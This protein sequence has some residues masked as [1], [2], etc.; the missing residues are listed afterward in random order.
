MSKQST[1]RRLFNYAWQFKRGIILGIIF[2]M[3]ATALE[4]A[5]PFIAKTIIDDHI[6]GIESVWYESEVESEASTVSFNGKTYVRED[7]MTT[8][9][10]DQAITI[11][12]ID[13]D[14]YAVEGKAPLEGSRTFS[15]GKMTIEATERVQ[16]PAEK[17]K[18]SELYHFFKVEQKPIFY[19]LLLYVILLLIAAVFEYFQTYKLQEASNQIIRQMRNDVF[20][21]TQKI[22]LSYYVDQPAGKIVARITNDTEAIRE[23]YERVLSIVITR[24]IYM[25]GILVAIYLLQ[26]KIAL[27]ALLI[28]PLI[29]VWAWIYKYFG[30]RFNLAIRKANSEINGTINESIQGMSIIQAFQAEKRRK[31]QFEELN[32]EIYTEQKK[33]ITLNALTSFNLVT[34]IRNLTFVC[35]IV[36]FGNLSFEP[37]TAISIGMLYA[38][39]DYFN[40]FFEPVTA[41]VNQFPLIEQARASGNRM[42]ALMDQE[43]ETMDYRPIERYHGEIQFKD[44]SFAYEKDKYI[45]HHISFHVQPGETAAFVGPT[46]S[47]KSTIMNLLF[48]FYDPQNGEITIDGVPTKELSRQQVRSHMGIVL[49]D[50]FLFTGTII[51]NVT[52]NNPNISREEAIRALQAVGADRFISQ[53]PKGYDEAVTEGGRTYSLGER[54]LISFARALAYDPAILI[55]DEAT[56]NIDTETEQTIQEALRIIQEDRTTLIIAHRLSTIQEADK[57]FV[58]ENGKIKEQGTHETLLKAKGIY[59]DMYR[60]QKGTTTN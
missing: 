12:A 27:I 22:P 54:Q 28:V 23:L 56:A 55:L 31:R 3:V 49:Q 29:V 60:M 38:L 6:L 44:V 34:F 48:R 39:V 19:W 14:Y 1:E 45:L 13:R 24:V 52:M 46:G 7:R 2:L 35:F 51:S 50:P 43:A 32:E 40:R 16:L 33:L 58:L 25:V 57:I 11:L 15:D 37:N 17:L 26:P 18:V 30:S 8:P 41:I 53:L 47:G 10:T 21:H 20:Q 4:L 42:F 9:P 36:Y 5:G 59:Y